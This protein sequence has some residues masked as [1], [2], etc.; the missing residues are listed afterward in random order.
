MDFYQLPNINIVAACITLHNFQEIKDNF[1]I[2]EWTSRNYMFQSHTVVP[3]HNTATD[4]RDAIKDF[5]T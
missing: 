5:L 4:I 1:N 2:E 3:V